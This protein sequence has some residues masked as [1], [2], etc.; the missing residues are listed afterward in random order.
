MALSIAIGVVAAAVGGWVTAALANHHRR[1]HAVAL[2][3]LIAL[4]ALVSLIMRP[5]AGAI[6]TQVSAICLMA[7]AAVLGSWP[8]WGKDAR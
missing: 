1:L 2:G 3:V 4:G 5:G 7:P 8:W 6:W